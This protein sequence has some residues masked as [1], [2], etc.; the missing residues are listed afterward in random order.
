VQGR[1]QKQQPGLEPMT[2]QTTSTHN[3]LHYTSSDFQNPA[4]VEQYRVQNAVG[5]SGILRDI[6]HNPELVTIYFDD[7]KHFLISAI[8]GLD[9]NYLY[10]D[11]GRDEELNQKLFESK[12]LIIV[13][14]HQ[15]VHVEFTSK[16]AEKTTFKNEPCIAVPLPSSI[17]K[18]QRREYYRLI[19]PDRPPVICHLGHSYDKQII[20][21]VK[22][23]SLGG[24]S[25][26]MTNPEEFSDWRQNMQIKECLI[27]LPDYADIRVSI[28]VKNLRELPMVSDKKQ[29]L[30]GCQFIEM[31]PKH[32][33]AVQRYI[34][35]VELQRRSK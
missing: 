7:E 3:K 5:I 24:I 35:S 21:P 16:Q 27:S 34:H 11:L 14:R 8:I 10:L 1:I 6:V 18:L 15:K 26:I 4:E 12:F 30:I 23:I 9:D 2:N 19:T 25:F 17:I 33:A 13:S 22:D 32:S 20:V 28:E 31:I 29:L